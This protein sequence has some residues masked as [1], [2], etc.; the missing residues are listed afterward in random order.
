MILLTWLVNE[1]GGSIIAVFCKILQHE[2]RQKRDTVSDGISFQ[3]ITMLGAILFLVGN[4]GLVKIDGM[5]SLTTQTVS[6]K[7]HIDSSL[8]NLRLNKGSQQ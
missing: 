3:L 4:Q 8:T 1:T 7:L 2:F 5:K 6:T